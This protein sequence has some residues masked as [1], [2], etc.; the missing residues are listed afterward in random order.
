MLDESAGFKA[1]RV[2]SKRSIKISP[3]VEPNGDPIGTPIS[4]GKTYVFPL[5]LQKL[6]L[7]QSLS[8]VKSSSAMKSGTWASSSFLL[9][10][11]SV[12]WCGRFGN[13][14]GT[15]EEMREEFIGGFIALIF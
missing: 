8:W 9:K 13:S 12:G 7:R 15:S 3:S 6:G 4:L 10:W 11:F 2:V 5:N 1:K 14:P